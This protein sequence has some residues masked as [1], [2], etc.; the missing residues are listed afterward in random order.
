MVDIKINKL[1][2]ANEPPY[3]LLEEAD[4]SR[5]NIDAYLT[6]GECFVAHHKTEMVGVLV[7]MPHNAQIIEIKNVAIKSAYRGQGIGSYLLKYSCILASDRSFQKVIIGTGNSSI[8]QIALYQKLGFEMY[9]LRQ[10]YF[11]DHYA[12]VIIENG[13]Q[14]KHMIMFQKKLK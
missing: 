3:A 10:N 2:A 4:P 5:V 12:D 7:L 9:E 14:C 11:V 13:I 8:N 1:P 6:K